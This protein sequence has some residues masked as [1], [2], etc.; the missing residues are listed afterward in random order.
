M[1]KTGKTSAG[2]V[3]ASVPHLKSRGLK[4]P[5]P[6]DYDLSAAGAPDMS[7]DN[8]GS[9]GGAGSPPASGKKDPTE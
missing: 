6:A 1:A 5:K 3:P 4:N 2:A 7:K 9:G 8:D